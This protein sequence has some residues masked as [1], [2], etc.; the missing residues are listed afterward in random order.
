MSTM[1][2]SRKRNLPIWTWVNGIRSCLAISGF[3]FPLMLVGLVMGPP[4]SR[5]DLI[6]FAYSVRKGLELGLFM[7]ESYDMFNRECCF[8]VPPADFLSVSF[9]LL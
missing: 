4:L 5:D 6:S 9:P 3:S 7:K 2:M 8:F 1:E